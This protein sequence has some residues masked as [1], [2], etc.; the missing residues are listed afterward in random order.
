MEEDSELLYAY[1]RRGDVQSLA[2]LVRRHTVWMQ[3][4][5]RSL[6]PE[7]AD[8]DDAFQET[9]VKVIRSASSYRGGKVK[10]YLATVAL[11]VALDRIRRGGR[12]VRFALASFSEKPQTSQMWLNDSSPRTASS[13]ENSL[14]SSIL[15]SSSGTSPACRGIPNFSGKSERITATGLMFLL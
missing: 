5:L 7:A 6:L 9:W 14:R 12:T 10:S 3:A 15:A 1:S 4:L 8:A 13:C 11:S 2:A